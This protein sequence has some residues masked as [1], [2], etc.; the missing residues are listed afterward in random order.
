M[1]VENKDG[2]ATMLGTL[3]YLD[4]M[5]KDGSVVYFTNA[6]NLVLEDKQLKHKLTHQKILPGLGIYEL[7]IMDCL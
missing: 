5:Q 7:M 2:G 4:N 1:L 3:H 6:I